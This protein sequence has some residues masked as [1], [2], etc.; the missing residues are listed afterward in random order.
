MSIVM[1]IS[2]IIISLKKENYKN[3]M[4]M[5]ILG[6]I[7]T[8]VIIYES[9]IN[10]EIGVFIWNYNIKL[11]NMIVLLKIIVLL[12][13]INY[14]YIGKRFFDYEKMY[15]KEYI[16]LILIAIIGVLIIMMSREFFILYLAIELQNL[17]LYILTSLRRWRSKSIEGGMKYY[18]MGSFSSGLLIY[19]IIMLWGY[20]GTLD[21]IEI[22]YIIQDITL[23][24]LEFNYIKY[25]CFFLLVGLLFKLGVAPFHWWVPEIYE[26]APLIVTLFFSIIPKL[27]LIVIL[28]NI[29]I[30]I[31]IYLNWFFSFV[32]FVVCLFSL[33]LG[34]IYSLYQKKIVKF[35][36]YSSIF[37]AGFFMACFY[38]GT[39]LSL[40][41]VMYFFVPYMFLLLGIF[42]ILIVFRKIRYEKINLLWDLSL[43]ANSNILLG[44][45]IAILFF[46]LA[47]IPPLSGF[48]GKFF[49]LLSL[50]LNNNF[51]LFFILM[52]FSVISSFY[53]FRI[54]RFLFF[55]NKLD[56]IFLKP[57]LNVTLLS[58]YVFIAVFFILFFDYI[59]L[60][61]F[62]FLSFSNL[63]I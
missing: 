54:V 33:I 6:Y 28:Y 13:M 58:I 24:E 38:N 48:F 8:I 37:N 32:F 41:S 62:S 20:F 12:F 19:G 51:L 52:F 42:F 22:N 16:I 43:V 25:M 39:Y 14:I 11:D 21:Y 45:I 27:S 61:F 35:L 18:I 59:Y 44:F 56:Y 50:F 49:I 55:S 17:I 63:V 3:L 15:I 26:G 31:L 46:A 30:Y 1:L 60:F 53:Y 29:Y 47:G 36:A 5:V 57:Y 9:V 40:I 23:K 34:F 2:L 7:I 4:Q 10:I